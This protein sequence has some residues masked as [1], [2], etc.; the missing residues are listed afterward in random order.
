V[1]TAAAMLPE[2]NKEALQRH[3]SQQYKGHGETGW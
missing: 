2:T 3:P 1:R